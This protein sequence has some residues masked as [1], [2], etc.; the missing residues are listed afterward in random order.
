[1]RVTLFDYGAGNLHSLAK[2]LATVPGAEVRVQEDP[3]RALDTDVLVLPGVGAFGA[4]VARLKPGRDAMREALE[5]GLPCLGICL[6]MQLLFEGSDE[7]QGAGLGYFAGR[8]TRLAAKRVPEI[9]W[10]Q[11][12]DE[13]TL[14][15]ARLDTVYYAHSF[16]CRAADAS[17]V[18][19][20]TTHEADRFPA[21]VRRGRV[22][23]V[24]FHPEKSSTAG[25][26]FVQAFLREVAP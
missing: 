26:R 15:G 17:V 7:G 4:A 23:G 20:W 14:A 1:M 10:N 9:G 5:K 13:R 3:L 21:A 19:G 2:A 8:V 11:V 12:E 18:T 16:V 25:V 24:Q 6:G 22:V